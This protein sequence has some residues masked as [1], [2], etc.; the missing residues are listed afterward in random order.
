[1]ARLLNT[2]SGNPVYRIVGNGRTFLTKKD[3][4]FASN[5]TSNL[6]GKIVTLTME[7]GRI[8]AIEEESQ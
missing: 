7:D 1:M 2:A 6:V 5:I 4:Q 8:A 3:A